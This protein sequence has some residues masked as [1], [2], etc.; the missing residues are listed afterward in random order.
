M[1]VAKAVMENRLWNIT[2]L[3]YDLEVRGDF[4]N[5]LKAPGENLQK[6]GEGTYHLGMMKVSNNWLICSY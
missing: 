5:S 6:N 4:H 2:G 1:V 3:G